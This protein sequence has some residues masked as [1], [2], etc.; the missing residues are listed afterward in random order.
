VKLALAPEDEGLDARDRD[1]AGSL[2]DEGGAAGAIVKRQ[3][4]RPLRTPSPIA[5]VFAAAAG[6]LAAIVAWRLLEEVTM[7]N[8]SMPTPKPHPEAPK[9]PGAKPERR[10]EDDGS[11]SVAVIDDDCATPTR[12]FRVPA[13]LEGER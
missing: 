6:V 10:R 7:K 12:P 13:E 4:S 9:A 2:A 8:A 3:E 5:V 11:R 1:R